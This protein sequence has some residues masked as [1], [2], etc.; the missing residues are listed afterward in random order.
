[1]LLLLDNGSLSPAATLSLRSLATALTLRLGRLVHPVS[2]LH[3]QKIPADQ[4]DGIPTTNLEPLLKRRLEAGD[5]HFQILPLFFGPSGALTDYLPERLALLRQ[6]FPD[7]KVDLAPC[8]AGEN[9]ADCPVLADLLADQVR[10]TL[11]ALPPDAPAPHQVILT[12]HG[13]PKREV[14]AVRDSLAALLAARLAP[15]ISLVQPAS[16]ERRPEPDYDFNEPLLEN[17]L[18]RPAFHQG[19]TILSLLFLSPGRHAGPDGDIAQIC[20][21]AAQAHPGL[22]YALTPLLGTHPALVDLLVRR[23]GQL[24]SV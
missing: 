12:D 22:R 1:M 10:L 21:A 18:A 5:R 13:S 11:A 20:S 23:A 15:H 16:M 24:P 14:T 8:L 7:L 3:S 6:K 4:L 9:N 19:T 2:L 17:A